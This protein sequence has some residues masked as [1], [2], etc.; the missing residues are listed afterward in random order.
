DSSRLRRRRRVAAGLQPDQH[1]DLIHLGGGDLKPRRIGWSSSPRRSRSGA[2]LGAG[3]LRVRRAAGVR[4]TAA[5]HPRLPTPRAVMQDE[6]I[7]IDGPISDDFGRPPWI[8]P[9]PPPPAD[10]PA[11]CEVVVVGAGITG[12]AAALTAA[13]SGRGVTVIERCFGS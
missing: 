6:S 5:D 11:A 3:A 12:L 7:D 10:L 4:R 9:E 8:A 2:E 13:E 1:R